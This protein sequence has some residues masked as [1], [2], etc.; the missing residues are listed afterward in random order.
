M[1]D[2]V[3]TN[4]IISE[5]NWINL[6][7]SILQLLWKKDCW[8]CFF[9]FLFRPFWAR[10]LNTVPVLIAGI[11]IR[12]AIIVWWCSLPEKAYCQSKYWLAKKRY[13]PRSKKN[14]RTGCC[15]RKKNIKCKNRQYYKRNGH[16]FFWTGFGQGYLFYLLHALYLWRPQYILSQGWLLQAGKYC[17][18]TM[19]HEL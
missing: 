12:L 13:K 6:K 4:K 14:Y 17:G 15:N 11:L 7:N 16:C 8:L 5:R 3:C 1:I 2:A 9:I 19:A 10:K 18:C